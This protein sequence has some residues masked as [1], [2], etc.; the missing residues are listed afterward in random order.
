M[1]YGVSGVVRRELVSKRSKKEERGPAK[2]GTGERDQGRQESAA[3]RRLSIVCDGCYNNVLYKCGRTFGGI[4]S[5]PRERHHCGINVIVIVGFIII[6]VY[7][8]V[9]C[10]CRGVHIACAGC[11]CPIAEHV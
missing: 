11:G 5:S 10:M 7:L 4:N 2:A 1:S 8:F 3:C 6:L 9:I